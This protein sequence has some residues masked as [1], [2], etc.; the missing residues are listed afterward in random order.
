MRQADESGLIIHA[1]MLVARG[2]SGA[3]GIQPGGLSFDLGFP[4]RCF[5]S[6]RQLGIGVVEASYRPFDKR[7]LYFSPRLNEM[8]YQTRAI[9]GADGA[10]KTPTIIL[11]TLHRKSHL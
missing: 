6:V 7:Y 2:R 4:L 11:R 1:N 5:G 3:G 9:F 10:I 8:L